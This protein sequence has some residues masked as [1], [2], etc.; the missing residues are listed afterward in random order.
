MDGI[1]YVAY[2]DKAVKQVERNVQELHKLGEWPVAVVSDQEVRGVQTVLYQGDFWGT[3]REGQHAGR[4]IFLPG[5]VKPKLYE[6]SP[7]ECTLYLDS[8]TQVI[9]SPQP[10]FGLLDKWEFVAAIG[11]GWGGLLRNTQFSPLELEKTV[12]LW[13]TG[14]L[15]YINTGVLA[16]RKCDNCRELFERWGQEYDGF[17][18]W[19]EQLPLLRALYHVPVLYTMLPTAWNSRLRRGAY[20]YHPTGNEAVW[21]AEVVPRCTVVI[22]CYGHEEFLGEAVTSALQPNTVVIVVDDGSP[23]DV[24]YAL[25]QFKDSPV[26]LI[27]QENKGLPAAR[28]AGIRAS[29]SKVVLDLDADDRLVKG[30]VSRMY[31]AW[32]PGSWVY[33]DV[34]LFGD[35]SQVMRCQ[36]NEASLRHLQPTH[37]AIMYS[38]EE[39]AIAGGYDESLSAFTT[40]DFTLRLWERGIRPRKVDGA[41]VE[42]RKRRG[43]GM[44]TGIM[45][46][47]ERHLQ[48]L[49]ERHPE[50]F[51]ATGISQV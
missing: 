31:E 27:R 14:R 17:G 3:P 16:W 38:K 35:T 24:L 37:P 8:D 49:Y 50:F 20:I 46:D 48:E 42:Y 7:F 32:R 43:E 15:H 51:G 2:G 19:D 39:W 21:S 41:L 44:L 33:S 10:L 28:N 1:V 18:G 26:Y 30:A 22:P 4:R 25:K 34:R 13:G 45:Q 29:R 5:R 40:W 11:Q 9:Q 23:G 36:V 6:L 47:K 12:K